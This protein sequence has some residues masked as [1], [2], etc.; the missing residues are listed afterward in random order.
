MVVVVHK[1]N[2]DSEFKNWSGAPDLNQWLHGPESHALPSSHDDSCGFLL[3]SSSRPA[4]SFQMCTNLQ[5]DY[6]MKCCTRKS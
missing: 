2:D 3:D 6:Y 4:R 5:P 1:L